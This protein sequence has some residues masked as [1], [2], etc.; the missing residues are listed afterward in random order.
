MNLD[1]IQKKLFERKLDTT[2]YFKTA[3][4]VYREFLKNNKLLVFL[5]Y[6]L[7]LV[8]IGTDFFN[9]Y[10]IFKIVINEDRSPKIVSMLM[11]FGILE[12]IFSIIQLFLNGYY[13]KKIVMEIEDKKEFNLKKFILKILRLVSIQYCLILGFTV[14]VESLKMVSLG[15]I[16]LILQITAIIIAV[17]YF[18]YFEVYYIQ[19]DTGIISSINYSYQLSKGNRLRKIIPGIVLILISIIPTFVIAFGI[20]QV[21]RISFWF[22]IIVIAIFIVGVV[23]AGIYLQVLSSV[24]FLNVEYDF[25]KKQESNNEIE[26]TYYENEE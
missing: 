14:I 16:S 3:F 24:I 15:I 10:L 5:T 23:L 19:D 2:E 17:K 22:G 12:L 9:R 20:L 26:E 7:M 13:L 1:N 11:V 8:I 4:D 21:F 6:L 25:L 18:L